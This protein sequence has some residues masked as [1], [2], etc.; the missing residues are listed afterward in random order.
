MLDEA[1]PNNNGTNTFCKV[2]KYTCFKKRTS[3]IFDFDKVFV[4]INYQHIYWYYAVMYMEQKKIKIYNSSQLGSNQD[5]KHFLTYLK[6]EHTERKDTPL[7]DPGKW[8]L[9]KNQPGTPTQENGTF[10]ILLLFI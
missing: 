7:L 5:F 10:Y 8:C 6:D 9:I 3:D 4:P 2:K 1:S